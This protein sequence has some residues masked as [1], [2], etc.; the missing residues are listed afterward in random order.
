MGMYNLMHVIREDHL[1][2][3]QLFTEYGRLALKNSGTVPF[4]KLQFLVRDWHPADA[5]FGKEGGKIVLERLLKVS[6]DQPEEVNKLRS[7]ISSCFSHIDCFLLPYPG[8]K[9]A[10]D[11]SFSGKAEDMDPRFHSH[12]QNCVESMLDVNNLIPK[13]IAGKVVK[14]REMVDYFNKYLEIFNGDEIPEPKSIFESMAE[15]NNLHAMN[16]AK[17]LY[18]EQMDQLKKAAGAKA[19]VDTEL[20]KKHKQITEEAIKLFDENSKFGGAVYSMHFHDQLLKA[21]NE[22]F[23]HYQNLNDAKIKNLFYKA[24]DSYISQ[25]ESF[26]KREEPFDQQELIEYHLKFAKEAFRSF[27]TT[28]SLGSLA[29]SQDLKE[30]GQ[31]N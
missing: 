12:F 20:I 9:V 19:I 3:L 4:Q 31:G 30:Q 15:V 8:P 21:I 17:G 29:Y 26:C 11:P 24:K 6:S 13:M 23:I 18:I 25:M 28:D 22:K 7:H 2:H 27:H 1:Q 16:D 14:S 10:E 5:P